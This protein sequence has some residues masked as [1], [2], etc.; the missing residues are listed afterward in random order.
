MCKEAWYCD[1]HC[2]V[3]GRAQHEAACAAVIARKAAQK[4][5]VGRQD[6]AEEQWLGRPLADV[7]RA[8]E[9]GDAAAQTA[10]GQCY[11]NGEK[12]LTKSAEHAA[13]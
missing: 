9:R 13:E 10:L 4:E 3:R 11:Y 6:A 2:L 1:L 7:R 5:A 8:A 12:G